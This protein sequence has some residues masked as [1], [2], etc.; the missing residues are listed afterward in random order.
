MGYSPVAPGTVGAMAG[1]GLFFALSS[2]GVSLAPYVALSV[3]VTLLGIWAAEGCE[4]RFGVADDGRIV[5]DE[6]AGQLVTLTPILVFFEPGE[7]RALS[8]SAW[9]GLVVTGFVVFRVLDI[10]KPGPVRWAERRFHGG[11]GVMLD[12]LLAGV[13]GGMLLAVPCYQARGALS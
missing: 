13:I 1:V 10:W 9:W 8:V 7:L 3:A 5:I 11:L 6:V 2:Q 12:D 4:A